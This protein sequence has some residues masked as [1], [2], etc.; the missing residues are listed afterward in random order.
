MK[1]IQRTVQTDHVI[2]LDN[3]SIKPRINQV[4][5]MVKKT[6]ETKHPSEITAK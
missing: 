5:I 3:M 2:A 6:S 1:C 4:K